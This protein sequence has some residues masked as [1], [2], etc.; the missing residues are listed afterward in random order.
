MN[1]IECVDCLK[2][3]KKWIDKGVKWEFPADV[4]YKG[5][6]LCREHFLNRLINESIALDKK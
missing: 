6:S 2:E 1:L 5:N 3:K 4:F